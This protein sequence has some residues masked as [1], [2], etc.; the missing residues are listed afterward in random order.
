MASKRNIRKQIAKGKQAVHHTKRAVKA[1]VS[2]KKSVSASKG[3]RTAA[4][5]CSICGKKLANDK[6]SVASHMLKHGS[7]IVVGISKI[8]KEETSSAT[9][10]SA[11]E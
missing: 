2:A 1:A 8:I 6:V 9:S 10:A 4:G 7:N 11:S 5:T 3:S